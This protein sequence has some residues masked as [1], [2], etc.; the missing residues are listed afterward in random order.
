[1][2]TIEMKI[3]FLFNARETVTSSLLT[4]ITMVMVKSTLKISHSAS[5]IFS[6][7][8]LGEVKKSWFCDLVKP[9]LAGSLQLGLL[10]VQNESNIDENPKSS[11]YDQGLIILVVEFI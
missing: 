3:I 6:P 9:R 8:G 1:M 2:K 10:P 4:W 11:N 5:E 7:P